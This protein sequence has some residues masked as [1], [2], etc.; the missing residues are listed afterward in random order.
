M[1]KLILIVS[2]V[3]V[4]GMVQESLANDIKN[5]MKENKGMLADAA[6]S[7]AKNPEV[8]KKAFSALSAMHSKM[9]QSAKEKNELP[10]K[11]DKLPK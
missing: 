1:K 5:L 9:K 2:L 4:S 10:V 11:K 6:K 8:Q 3:F 7:A